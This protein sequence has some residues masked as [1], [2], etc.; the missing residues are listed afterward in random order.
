VLFSLVLASSRP[1]T[2]SSRR[3]TMKILI[4]RRRPKGIL[5]AKDVLPMYPTLFFFRKKSYCHIIR[6]MCILTPS[7]VNKKLE[8]HACPPH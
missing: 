7:D 3:L 8:R 1:E 4:P 2:S 5:H 6:H